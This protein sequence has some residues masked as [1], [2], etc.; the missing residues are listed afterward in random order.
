VQMTNDELLPAREALGRLCNAECTLKLIVAHTQEN[1]G[2][3]D[4]WQ[5]G[6]ALEGVLRLL[7]GCYVALSELQN[8][9][10]REAPPCP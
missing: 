7:D 6:E 3:V 4:G 1:N 2:M 10:T 9:V 8:Q 5:V